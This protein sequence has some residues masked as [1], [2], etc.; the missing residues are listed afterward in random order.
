MA[1][2]INDSR[3]CCIADN[4]SV[5]SGMLPYKLYCELRN[6]EKKYGRIE[7]LRCRKN[8]YAYI[9]VDRKSV[10]LDHV[11]SEGD[12]DYIF[13]AVCRGSLYAYKDT[14]IE[15][16]VTLDG[17]IRV[18]ICGRAAVDSGRILG[19]YDVSGLNFRFPTDISGVGK[20]ILKLLC[21]DRSKGILVFSPPGEGKT[22]LLRS[23]I[24]RLA[25]GDDARRVC[26][27]DTRGE[28]GIYLSGCGL[29]VDVLV[30][31]PKCKGIEIATRAMNAE[32]IVCDEIGD[33]AEADAIIAAQNCGVALVASAHGESVES[34]L[35]RTGILR[36]HGSEVFGYY[37]GI[38]R[39]VGERDFEYSVYSWEEADALA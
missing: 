16:Y 36:L 35:K 30:G 14:I 4:F 5:L 10:P 34:L 25:S 21:N 9:T 31:Y 12:I 28:L 15:G 22:T 6:A 17:G 2:V 13:N 23:V 24:R 20:P 26:V 19:I 32:L 33:P 18:G 38:R 29:T 8:R 11:T 27:V 37:V 39:A 3:V 7:E 1:T